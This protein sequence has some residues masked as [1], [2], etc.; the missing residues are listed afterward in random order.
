MYKLLFLYGRD[1]KLIREGSFLGE[2]NVRVGYNELCERAQNTY[3]YFFFVASSLENEYSSRTIFIHEC[4]DIWFNELLNHWHEI[5]NMTV[6][7]WLILD[8]IWQVRNRWRMEG[9][10]PYAQACLMEINSQWK[11]YRKALVVEECV[12]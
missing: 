8:N 12:L 5:H 2:C 4:P 7:I 11:E 1:D 9:C 10:F 3:F 6:L